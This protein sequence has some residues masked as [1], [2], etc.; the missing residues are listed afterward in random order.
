MLGRLLVNRLRPGGPLGLVPRDRRTIGEPSTDGVPQRL[1]DRDAAVLLVAPLH[2]RPGRLCGARRADRLLPGVDEPVVH[3]PVLPLQL[4]H[5]PSGQ[6]V[7]F[8]RL[9]AHAL[10]LLVEVHPELHDQRAIVGERLLELGDPPQLEVELDPRHAAVGAVDDRARIPRVQEKAEAAPGR[11]LPPE[12]PLLG[13]LA[14]LVRG[15]AERPRRNPARIHPGVEQVDGLAFASAVDAG[16]DHEHGKRCRAQLL[17]RTEQGRPE[18]GQA[19]LVRLLRERSSDFSG[20]EHGSPAG[21]VGAM[22]G[23]ALEHCQRRHLPLCQVHDPRDA[24]STA[25]GFEG[26]EQGSE[27]AAGRGGDKRW[28]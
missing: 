16:E 8:E 12:S 18:C 28:R 14:L 6:R 20:F 13:P 27:A 2:D 23:A 5:A 4:G 9:Q 19:L 24:R 26:R 25:S 17:L 7:A 15:I 10:G 22:I 21:F 1:G 3:L 11:Q